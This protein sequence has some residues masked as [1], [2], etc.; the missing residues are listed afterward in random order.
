MQ[1]IS[2]RGVPERSRVEFESANEAA[3]ASRHNFAGQISTH[4]EPHPTPFLAPTTSFVTQTKN[5]RFHRCCS[6]SFG[7]VPTHSP[8]QL[9]GF[10]RLGTLPL[11]LLGCQG[12]GWQEVDLSNCQQ[13]LVREEGLAA[14]A[15][16]NPLLQLL[17]QLQ[18][19]LGLASLA[20]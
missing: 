11:Q 3:A 17:G 14:A 20:D 19:C 2:Y 10:R 12:G 1:D 13:L 16:L 4:R 15:R 7:R 8:R 18:G 5:K 9:G 6:R